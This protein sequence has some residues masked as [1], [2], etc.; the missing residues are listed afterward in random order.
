MAVGRT[1]IRI[2]FNWAAD[3]YKTTE[4]MWHQLRDYGGAAFQAAV[5]VVGIDVY[6]GT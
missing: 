2:G 6:P 3:S 4:P 1:G 5:G